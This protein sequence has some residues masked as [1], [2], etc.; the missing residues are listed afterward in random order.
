LKNNIEW[1]YGLLVGIF[2]ARQKNW[3]VCLLNQILG[4]FL[5]VST[6]KS[7]DKSV[8]DFY[9]YLEIGERFF[10]QVLQT[11]DQSVNKNI[12]ILVGKAYPIMSLSSK[13]TYCV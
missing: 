2:V 1:L 12:K 9:I 3:V 5:W 8:S 13:K 4:C 10:K 7:L 6:K 11:L